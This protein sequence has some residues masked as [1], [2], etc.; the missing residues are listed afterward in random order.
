[1]A[2]LTRKHKCFFNKKSR[3]SKGETSNVKALD[4]I[5]FKCRNSSHIQADC[6]ILNKKKRKVMYATWD[7]IDKSKSE[8]D[9]VEE[10]EPLSCFMPCLAR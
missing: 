9:F 10:K 6:S 1:M 8:E 2:L 7:E 5:C 4:L 3:R